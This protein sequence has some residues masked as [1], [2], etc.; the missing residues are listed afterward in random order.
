M[1]NQTDALSTNW[2]ILLPIVGATAADWCNF[3][4]QL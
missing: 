4:C 1:I 3:N 2:G